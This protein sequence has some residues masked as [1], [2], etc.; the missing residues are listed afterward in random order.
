MHNEKLCKLYSS[1][2][3]RSTSGSHTASYLMGTGG[4]LTG[5]KVATALAWPLISTPHIQLQDNVHLLIILVSKTKII[6]RSGHGNNEK[7]IQIFTGKPTRKRPLRRHIGICK[8]DIQ[9]GIKETVWTGFNWWRMRS[10][11]G[12][13]R[14]GSNIRIHL[15]NV[16]VVKSINKFISVNDI[17]QETRNIYDKL[18]LVLYL[19]KS[20][21]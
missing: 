5:G 8:E 4:S 17:R 9:L 6:R 19:H 20:N 1:W 7:F 3:I 12:L 21:Y 11:D 14:T 13:L 18:A 15:K 10:S 16:I 2:N